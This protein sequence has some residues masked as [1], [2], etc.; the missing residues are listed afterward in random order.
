LRVILE[1]EIGGD[2]SNHCLLSFV[3]IPQQFGS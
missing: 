2:S 1:R 3:S